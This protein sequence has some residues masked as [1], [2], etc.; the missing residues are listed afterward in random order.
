MITDYT[1]ALAWGMDMCRAMNRFGKFRK[2]LLKLVMGRYAY[3]EL[4]GLR[5]CIE[6]YGYSTDWDYGLEDMKYHK[7]K[8]EL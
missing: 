7:D 3:R 8:V 1:A 2:W 6:K 4:I 5:D